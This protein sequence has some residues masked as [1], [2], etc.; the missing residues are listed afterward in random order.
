MASKTRARASGETRSGL[1]S[2]RLTVAV[3][4]SARRATSWMRAAGAPSPSCQSVSAIP[5]VH[6]MLPAINRFRR[7]TDDDVSIS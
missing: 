6:R 3:E 4:T 5:L 7:L 2:A 1:A